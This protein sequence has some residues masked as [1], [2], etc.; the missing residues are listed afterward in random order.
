MGRFVDFW[1]ILD[2]T[3]KFFISWISPWN[4]KKGLKY[5][6]PLWIKR[7]SYYKKKKFFL[8][9]F[10]VILERSISHYSCGKDNK[11][12]HKLFAKVIKGVFTIAKASVSSSANPVFWIHQDL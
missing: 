8:I 12:Y 5:R 9:F 1:K 3:I 10:L 6:K 11:K 2:E 4:I 7:F